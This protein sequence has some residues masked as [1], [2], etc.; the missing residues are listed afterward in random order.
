MHLT[1]EEGN[2]AAWLA[3]V[4][5]PHVRRLIACHPRKNALLKSG[6]KSDRIDA[7]KLAEPLRAG[8]L[9]P[10]YHDPSPPHALKELARSYITPVRNATRV[11]NRLKA[12]YRGRG[13]RCSGTRVYSHRFRSEW[14]EQLPELGVR[15]RAELLYAKLDLVESLRQHA[16]RAL[17]SESRKHPAGKILRTIPGPGSVRAAL[18]L[19]W[20]QTPCR[21]SSKRQLWS[22][23][24]L[25]LVSR[26]SAQYQ[27]VKGE[28]VSSSRR[29]S[30]RGHN[31]EHSPDLKEIFEA[32]AL[33]ASCRHG[34]LQ[35]FFLARAAEGIRSG[36]P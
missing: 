10:V 34:P 20:M 31:R 19:A 25:G 1:L 9:K 28:I 14:S 18:L 2:F 21:F 22:H 12:L 7:R 30:L 17:L 26:S 27:T 15:Q 36:S 13:I 32:A 3:E 6:N 29:V 5:P 23:A 11:M 4:P 24:G 35:D 16:R 8:L 33:V